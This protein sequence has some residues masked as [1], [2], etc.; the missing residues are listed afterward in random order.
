MY[1]GGT[2]EGNESL[3]YFSKWG[4]YASIY[5]LGNGVK[6]EIDKLLKTNIHEIHVLLAIRNDTMKLKY[7]IQKQ[8]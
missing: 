6:S 4:F 7:K 8:K 3:S 5:D 2:N 1:A